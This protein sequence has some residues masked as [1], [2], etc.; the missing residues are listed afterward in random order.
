MLTCFEDSCWLKKDFNVKLKPL[1]SL[2][3]YLSKH[4]WIVENG[5]HMC[6]SVDFTRDCSWNPRWARTSVGLGLHHE[7]DELD[8]H[9]GPPP[10]LG[11]YMT[12]WCSHHPWCCLPRCRLCRAPGPIPPPISCCFLYEKPCASFLVSIGGICRY[13]ILHGAIAIFE[14]LDGCSYSG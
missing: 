4:I 9:T 2:S 7:K 5:V 13:R 11:V 10:L 6:P 8:A 12:E 1:E 3:S 14:P